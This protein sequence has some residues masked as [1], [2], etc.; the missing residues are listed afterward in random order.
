MIVIIFAVVALLACAA[1]AAVGSY[2]IVAAIDSFHPDAI[3][4]AVFV[5]VFVALISYC[6]LVYTEAMKLIQNQAL[7]R[8]AAD[9]VYRVAVGIRDRAIAG[10]LYLVVAVAVVT[11]AAALADKEVFIT[12]R[13]AFSINAGLTVVALIVLGWLISKH[14]EIGRF[15]HRVEQLKRSDESRKKTLDE[16]NRDQLRPA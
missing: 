13:W 11:L 8:R 4:A 2:T 1:A 9:R 7:S 6:G 15:T 12:K 5:A 14:R 10:F 3:P 16:M